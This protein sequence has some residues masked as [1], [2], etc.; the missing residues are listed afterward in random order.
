MQNI[1]IL[2]NEFLSQYSFNNIEI[3]LTDRKVLSLDEASL[4][5]K[6]ITSNKG[7]YCFENNELF[8]H[9]LKEKD[10][11][12]SRK[13]GRVV[14]GGDRDVPRTHQLSVVELEEKLYIAD[15]GFGPYTPGVCVPLDGQEVTAFNGNSYKVTK[16]NDIDFRLTTRRGDSDF[17]L[18]EFNL[19]EYL[20]SDFKLSNYYTN[21][22]PDS[23]FTTSFILSKLTSKGVKFFSNLTFCEMEGESRSEFEF[24]TKD[25]FSQ[26]I[27][28]EFQLGYSEGELGELFEI[29]KAFK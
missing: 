4:R 2:I 12:V 22:H 17:S 1:N 24:S 20:N 11:R 6:I 16:V 26:F 18:Y 29:A 10:Y 8:Y 13:L 23:K 3:L 5:S 14:Y 9:L 21:T 7:G 27:K 19:S 15:V 28:N 25:K